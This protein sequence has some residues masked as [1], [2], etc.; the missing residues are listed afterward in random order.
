MPIDIAQTLLKARTIAVVGCSPRPSRASHQIAAYLQQAGYRV[1]P[2]NPYHDELI[3]EACYPDLV[4][5]PDDVQVDI[6][7]VFRHPEHTLDVVQDAADRAERTHRKPVIWT[8]VGVHSEDARAH[9]EEKGMPYIADSCIKVE[10][11]R[12]GIPAHP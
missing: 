3:E 5:I 12:H 1:I 6:V 10:H 2:V 4:S 9:A 7:N 11:V 8:Q